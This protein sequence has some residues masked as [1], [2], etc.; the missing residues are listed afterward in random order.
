MS[1]P[2]S[3][4]S[5]GARVAAVVI[6]GSLALTSGRTPALAQS[7]EG[8]ARAYVSIPL[9]RSPDGPAYGLRLDLGDRNGAGRGDLGPLSNDPPPVLEVRFGRGEEPGEVRLGGIAPATVRDRMDLDGGA[10]LWIWAGLGLAAA[11]AIV[12]AADAICIGI[13]T[14]C[15]KDD[16]NDDK[17]EGTKRAQA[18]MID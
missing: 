8:Y 10:A 2:R 4:R 11:V 5:E 15:A 14:S 12:V 3:R 17:D 9:A 18:A 6:V 7:V 1:G 13:N 16:D